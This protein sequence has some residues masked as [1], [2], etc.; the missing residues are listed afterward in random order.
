MKQQLIIIPGWGGNRKSWQNFIDL[1]KDNF[2]VFFIDMPCFGDLPCPD[3][4][5]GVDEYALFV[6]KKVEDLNLHKP[7]LLGHSFGGQVAANL[8]ATNPDLFSLLILS[9]AAILRPSYTLKRIIFKMIATVGK[10][11]FKLPILRP[12]EKIARR[13]LYKAA[14]SPDYEETSGVKREIFKKIIRQSQVHL[15]P[16]IKIPSLVIWGSEDSYVS[17]SQ[18][19]I[20]AEKI[21]NAE[22]RVVQGGNHGLHIQQPEN[23]Y[24]IISKFIEN[25]L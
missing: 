23:L 18:G 25:K 4:V 5:W 10:M 7:I 11:I 2:E 19:K 9:G 21:P 20:I 3:K 13:V 16:Q 8:T 14:D 12:V 17:L 22:L 15:L 1:A 6:K 24:K